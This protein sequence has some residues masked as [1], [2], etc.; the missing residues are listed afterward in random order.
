MPR[1]LLEASKDYAVMTKKAV[2]SFVAALE[3]AP[4]TQN[5]VVDVPEIDD[6]VRALL[7]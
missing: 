7:R 4:V 1:F 2:F 5:Q 3:P 6:A